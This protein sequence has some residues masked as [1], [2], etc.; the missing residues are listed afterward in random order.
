MTPSQF[1]HDNQARWQRLETM[2][3]SIDQGKAP[4]DVEELPTLFRQTCHDLSLA[5][6]RMYG[7][8][9]RERLNTLATQTYRVL[10]RRIG[11]GWERLYRLLMQEF[12]RAV[13]SEPRLFWLCTVL[14]WAPFFFFT[15]WTPHDPE[16]AMRV[17]GPEQM[18][19]VEEMYGHHTSPEEFKREHFGSDFG[20]FCFYIWNNVSIDLRT[21]ASGLLFGVGT[22]FV[23][24]YNGL[25]IGC[26]AGYVHHAC[27]METFYSFVAGHSAPELMGVVISGMAGLKLG[28]SLI[29]PGPYDRKTALI[30]GGR[31]AFLL[32]VGACVMTSFAAVIEGFW[33]ATPMAPI[34]KYLFGGII[35][36]VTLSYLAF[37]GREANAG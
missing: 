33:S 8:R 11:G 32:I 10:E 25:M 1:E 36:V 31:K 22:I 9:V 27:N 19:A 37:S 15:F 6:H 26:T 4:E 30:L 3:E 2:L 12:P 16:W 13:R 23:V 7:N 20:M 35:W 34:I 28:F 5:R 21:F 24:V 17:L 18:M 14:F 29:K